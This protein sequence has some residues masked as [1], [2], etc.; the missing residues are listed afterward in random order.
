[1]CRGQ[2]LV[3]ATT[4]ESQRTVFRRIAQQLYV[5]WPVYDSTPLY[6]RTSLA[7]LESDVRVVSETWFGHDAHDSV[8]QFV[9]SLPLT[10]FLFEVHDRYGGRTR[11]EM[12][13]LFRVFVLKELHGWDHETALVEYLPHHPRLCEQL[14]FEMIPDQS[15]LW[16]SW[17]KRFTGDLCET[18]KTAARTILIKAQ[19]AGI[20]IPRDPERNI[21]HQDGDAKEQTL[22][23]LTVLNQAEKITD[24]VSRVVFPAFSL[25]RGEGCEIYENAYWDL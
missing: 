16:R 15:T 2:H 18:V 5:K 4:C 19:N 1:M 12:D 20:T 24:H 25:D 10:Y 13:T 21:Q 8:E 22:D 9:C 23:D 3:V 11:Y 6:D 17:N 14:D 7:G